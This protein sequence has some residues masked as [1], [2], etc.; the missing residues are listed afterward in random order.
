[1][2]IGQLVGL[3]FKGRKLGHLNIYYYDI[4][5]GYEQHFGKPHPLSQ[6]WFFCH[7]RDHLERYYSMDD[8]ELKSFTFDHIFARNCG[9][10]F[11]S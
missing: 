9:R 5:S 2:G 1:M 7:K 11:C 8:G 6:S 3:D 10:C 4:Q